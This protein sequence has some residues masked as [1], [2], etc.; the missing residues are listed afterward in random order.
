[1]KVRSGLSQI[2]PYN[3]QENS[4]LILERKCSVAPVTGALSGQMCF[5]Q[6]TDIPL[7]ARLE[8]V[9]DQ[10]KIRKTLR[11]IQFITGIEADP[12][13]F[14]VPLRHTDFRLVDLRN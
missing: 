10:G 11:T 6:E 5:D 13:L 12:S 3:N 1:M 7:S 4:E 8:E 14:V 2:K 9:S